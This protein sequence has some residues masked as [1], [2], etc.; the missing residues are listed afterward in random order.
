MPAASVTILLKLPPTE[1]MLILSLV[2]QTAPTVPLTLAT[3]RKGGR[4]PS[5]EH[6]LPAHSTTGGGVYWFQASGQDEVH[7]PMFEDM[8]VPKGGASHGNQSGKQKTLAMAGAVLVKAARVKAA[9]DTRGLAQQVPKTI[10]AQW[11][12]TTISI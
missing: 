11:C 2:P 5:P 1:M 12:L 4:H 7:R 3:C 6:T 9:A 10:R 8:L